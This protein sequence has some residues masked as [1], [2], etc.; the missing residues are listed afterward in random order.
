MARLENYEIIYSY[1]NL[2]YEKLKKIRG[3]YLLQQSFL[4]GTTSSYFRIFVYRMHFPDLYPLVVLRFNS[5][6]NST[7]YF[8]YLS[9]LILR[10]HPKIQRGKSVR[11]STFLLLKYI[12]A[13]SER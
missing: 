6:F 4:I 1:S 7:E 10:K 12:R 9:L 3:R 8:I 11:E 13:W 5:I 2:Y